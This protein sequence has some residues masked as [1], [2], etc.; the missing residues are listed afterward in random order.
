MKEWFGLKSIGML[1]AV[2]VYA[3]LILLYQSPVNLLLNACYSD[4]SGTVFQ[5]VFCHCSFRGNR[6]GFFFFL[7]VWNGAVTHVGHPDAFVAQTF[8][9]AYCHLCLGGGAQLPVWQT[10]K[11]L[12]KEVKDEDAQR[13][14][15]KVWKPGKQTGFSA[16]KIKPIVKRM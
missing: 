11:R 5:Y 10:I 9:M 12:L 6:L 3:M 8:R 2:F 7:A 15:G 1:K 4:V 14:G 16:D 13:E